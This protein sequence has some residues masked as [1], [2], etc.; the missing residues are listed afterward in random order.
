MKKNS[1]FMVGILS[2]PLKNNH[3]DTPPHF[4]KINKIF[5][6]LIY[7]HVEKKK[8]FQTADKSKWIK[9]LCHA[10]FAITSLT[11]HN[12]ILPFF[13][14]NTCVQ[15]TQYTNKIYYILYVNI[16]IKSKNYN[17]IVEDR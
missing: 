14:Q 4:Q 16:Q 6:F 8:K 2:Y 11:Y 13:I 3:D 7:Y 17:H 5:S 12:I 9:S 1:L 15:C 10:Q